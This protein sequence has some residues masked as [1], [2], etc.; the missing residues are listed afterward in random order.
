MVVRMRA[1]R[2][3]RD[4][5]RA[6][7]ALVSPRFSRCVDCGTPH[8]RHRV[9]TTCGKYKG[10]QALNVL[11]KAERRAKKEKEKVS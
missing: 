4:N 11:A 5:R 9:C 10:K 3:H 7:F 8:L 6:H 1:N 2:A